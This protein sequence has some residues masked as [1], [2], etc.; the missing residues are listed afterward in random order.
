[1]SI[2]KKDFPGRIYIYIEEDKDGKYLIACREENEAADM[3]EPRLVG[4][5]TIEN[6]VKMEVS[7]HM[8]NATLPVGDG[9]ECP[10]CGEVNYC[11]HRDD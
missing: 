7:V 5:Y 3:N 4:I 11:I 8:V 6:V 2:S 10:I 1:M 9:I